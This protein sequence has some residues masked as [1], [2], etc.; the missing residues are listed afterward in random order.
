MNNNGKNNLFQLGK[1]ILHSGEKS[2]FKIDCDNLTDEDLE[3][4][5]WIVAREWRLEYHAVK[6]IWRGGSKF[7]EKLRRYTKEWNNFGE[8]TLLIVDDVL[9]TGKSMDE[10][11]E[12]WRHTKSMNV[13]GI[14]IFSRGKCPSWVRPIFRME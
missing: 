6:G 4:L 13:K 2:D 8:N 1:F 10:M 7:A 11:Y 12:T 3:T 14:V 9:T 5:A